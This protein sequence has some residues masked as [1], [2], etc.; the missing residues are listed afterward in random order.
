MAASYCTDG[1]PCPAA[2][3]IAVQPKLVKCPSVGPY[4][5]NIFKTLS[6]R[7]RWADVDK[8]CHVYSMGPETKLLGS[9]ILNFC[10]CTARGSRK[11]IPSGVHFNY[12]SK[13]VMLL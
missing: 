10:P 4:G 3:R 7:D 8:T 9:G 6:L 11:P 1:W 2:E 5:V 12:Y 13:L